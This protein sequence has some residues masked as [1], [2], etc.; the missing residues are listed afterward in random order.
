MKRAL[1]ALAVLAVATTANA[2]EKKEKDDKVTQQY[3][4][5]SP[6][7]LPVV[8]NNKVVNYVFVNVRI[9]LTASADSPRMR[10]R[11]P[12]FRDAL[13]RAAH[14]TPFTLAG[15]Y[16]KID[17]ARLKAAVMRDA[18]TIA[19]PNVIKGV[20]VLNQAPKSSRVSAR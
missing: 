12:Y 15:D 17:E 18:V 14:R 10:E 2:S 9:D 5:I 6:V 7:A 11:E 19:G 3:V 1:T 16:T 4:A 20:Q 8:V 13:V